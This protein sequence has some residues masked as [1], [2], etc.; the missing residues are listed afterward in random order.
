[1]ISRDDIDIIDVH[2]HRLSRWRS[3]LVSVS[4]EEVVSAIAECPEARFSTGLHPWQ[5]AEVGEKQLS[6]LRK[7]VERPEVLAVGETGLDGLRGAPAGRQA[8]ILRCHVELSESA[9]KPLIVHLVKCLDEMLG[10][11]RE[12]RPRQPWVIHGFRGKP[13]QARTLLDAG[14][15]LSFGARFNPDTVRYVPA[16]RLLTETDES[17]ADISEV[18]AAV[19]AARGESVAEAERSVRLNVGRLFRKNAD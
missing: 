7:A 5:S 3:A 18:I 19:A 17:A 10:L 12:M 4:P 6:A 16:D 2:T 8:E 14:C 9:G 13:Q 1:M 15:M 11:R